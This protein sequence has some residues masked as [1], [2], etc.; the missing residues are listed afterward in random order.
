MLADLRQ[1]IKQIGLHICREVLDGQLAGCGEAIVVTPSRQLSWPH[2]LE[3]PPGKEALT[4]AFYAQMCSIERW[5]VRTLRERAD[6]MLPRARCSIKK[7]MHPCCR[8]GYGWHRKRQTENED[9]H[10]K[11]VQPP[12][13]EMVDMANR[14]PRL[15]ALQR[16][17]P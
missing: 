2:F 3:L 13:A 15:A 11:N 1:L 5:N 16:L 12:V 7:S 6:S 10:P 9:A 14:P 4:R 17:A 8:H